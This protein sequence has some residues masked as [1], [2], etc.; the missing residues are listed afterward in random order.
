MSSAT[1]LDRPSPQDCAA[2]RRL[3]PLGPDS[4]T[5]KGRGDCGVLPLVEGS[6]ELEL[7]LQHLDYF[8]RRRKLL[9]ALSCLRATEQLRVIS[10]RTDDVHWLRYEMEARF[11]ARYHWSASSED[12]DPAVHTVV[13]RPPEQP[14]CLHRR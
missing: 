7:D 6:D 3:P 13:R 9:A 2:S 1:L 5:P 14:P 12:R 10:T 4:A 8:T 11:A